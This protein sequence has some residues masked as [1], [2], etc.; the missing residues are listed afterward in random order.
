MPVRQDAGPLAAQALAAQ[1]TPVRGGAWKGLSMAA[2]PQ[3]AALSELPLEGPTISSSQLTELTLAKN[4]L[5]T[6]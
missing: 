4:L 1:P 6:M 3:R 5:C 2:E